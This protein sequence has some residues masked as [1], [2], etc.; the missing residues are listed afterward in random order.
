MN[1]HKKNSITDTLK[2]NVEHLKNKR[3]A[4][5]EKVKKQSKKAREAKESDVDFA[6]HKLRSDILRF[7]EEGFFIVNTND[8]ISCVPE[9]SISEGTGLLKSWKDN[10]MKIFFRINTVTIFEL[11]TK[12]I[13][14]EMVKAVTIGGIVDSSKK[15]YRK[16]NVIEVI[17]FCGIYMLVENMWGNENK[18]C[19]E[20]FTILKKKE[21][22]AMGHQ[23]FFTLRKSIVPDNEIFDQLVSMWVLNSQKY[24]IPGPQIS[25][26]E[27]IYAYQVKSEMK[28]QYIEKK[29]P[30]P[31]HY[32]PR[33]PH[34]NGLFAWVAATKSDATNKPFVLDIIPHYK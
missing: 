22:F 19:V 16:T 2:S 32:V 13:N 7:K 18:D 17:Q 25:V 9:Y 20:N 11:I 27:S 8:L 15:Y 23:R 30:A 21:Q 14:D 6:F 33:K 24:W 1:N 28:E 29:D 3:K 34:P 5:Q 12:V 10:P 26:D 31:V 4:E